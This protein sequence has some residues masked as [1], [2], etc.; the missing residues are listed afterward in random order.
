MNERKWQYWSYFLAMALT[1]GTLPH[2]VTGRRLARIRRII[3][4]DPDFWNDILVR[5]RGD[6]FTPYALRL[7]DL[8]LYKHCQGNFWGMIVQTMVAEGL[9][10]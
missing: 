2:G 4:D 3:W 9:I 1:N 7:E 10:K 5:H 8:Q 6:E